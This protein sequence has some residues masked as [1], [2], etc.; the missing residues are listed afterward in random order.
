MEKT[1]YEKG[2]EKGLQEGRE[3]G[4]GEG[5]EK[6]LRG[7]LLVL[8]QERF[9]TLSPDALAR[10]N[11]CQVDKLPDMGRSLLHADSLKDLGLED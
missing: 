5:Q 1:T 7:L 6:A 11:A 8:L 3:K 9:G 10:F 2:L 4:L